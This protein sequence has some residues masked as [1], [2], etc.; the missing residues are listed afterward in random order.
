MKIANLKYCCL[1]AFTM[2]SSYLFAQLPED[3]LRLSWTVP[4]GTAREQAIGGAMGSL[5]GEISSLFVNPAGLATYRTNEFVLSPGFRFSKNNTS[6]R[7][8]NASG[9]FVNNFNVGTSGAVV[10]FTDDEDGSNNVVGIAVNQTTSFKNNLFYTGQNDYSS[11]ADQ[12]AEEYTNS[13]LS[14]NDAINSSSVSYGTRMALYTYLID[15]AT[16]NGTNQIISLPGKAGLLN[17][18]NNIYSRGSITEVAL[19]Y[20]GN[21]PR[22]KKW[23]FGITLGI[24]IV[25]YTRAQ[26]FTETDATGN[27]N[28]DF[29]SSVYTE[30]YTSK[31]VGFN[32]KA[33][34]IFNPTPAWHIGLAVHS[35]T[36][37]IL[38][39]NISSS[40]TTNTENYA[41]EVSVTSSQLDDGAGFAAN[42]IKYDFASPWKFLASG[43]YI[44]GGEEQDVKNQKGFITA[45]VEYVTNRTMKFSPD[46]D[47]NGNSSLPDGYFSAVN[48]AIKSIYKNSFNL[49]LGG[50]L[51]FD[52]LAARLGFAYYT[53]PYKQSDLTANRMYLSGGIGYRNKGV[54]IDLTYVRGFSKDVY[55]PYRLTDKANTFATVKQ[56]DGTILVT[57]GFK[58]L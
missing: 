51:K 31:G 24:P 12:F 29:A 50:E 49:R 9:N 7:G 46:V 18:Q 33:G 25:Y 11:Y 3:A 16:V 34:A 28:N 5:G 38:N 20:G 39:D 56:S 10:S 30:N 27:T 41:H 13:G 15:T 36:T 8:T 47:E 2:F 55:F 19:G 23:H 45:D 58:F 22:N 42:K 17:Q 1:L 48:T 57:V 4:S 14:I 54:F 53:S 52:I 35:P 21:L 26:T 44:F 32:L 40:M 37:Y 6:Y 43:S